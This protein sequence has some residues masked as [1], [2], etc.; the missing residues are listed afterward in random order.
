M[1][2]H[3]ARLPAVRIFLVTTPGL[4]RDLVVETLNEEPDMAIVGEAHDYATLERA[5]ERTPA[6]LV[7]W[8]VAGND[9]RHVCRG[10]FEAHA[11]LK[12]LTVRN[13]GRQAWLCE[14]Q[15]QRTELGEISPRLLV[16]TIRKVVSQ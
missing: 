5:L 2:E 10:L 9:M 4:L 15:P 1:S 8:T 11:Q 12:V 14:L 16:E 7:I 3:V 13:D 6:D